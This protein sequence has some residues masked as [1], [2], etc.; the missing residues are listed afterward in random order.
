MRTRADHH[1]VKSRRQ[2]PPAAV[3]RDERHVERE[4]VERSA[5]ERTQDAAAHAAALGAAREAFARLDE[6]DQAWCA[7]SLDKLAG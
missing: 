7:A 2:G 6:G 1:E 4:P 3:L 5:P